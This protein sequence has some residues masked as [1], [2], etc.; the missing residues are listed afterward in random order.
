MSPT[1]NRTLCVIDDDTATR[2]LVREVFLE[3]DI[4]V[5][6]AARGKD[7]LQLIKNY[8]DAIHAV[9]IDIRLPD[10]MGHELLPKLRALLP[11][12]PIIAI[13]ASSTTELI[14]KYEAK[15]FDGYISKPFN[16]D[17]FTEFIKGFLT[18]D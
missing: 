13:S 18:L 17:Y 8:P 10:C 1:T 9:L 12:V 5:I 11:D 4:H 16:I 3:T 6:E 14:N 15:N 7:A 2:I